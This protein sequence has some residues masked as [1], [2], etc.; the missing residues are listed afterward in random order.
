MDRSPSLERRRRSSRS[1]RCEVP[2]AAWALVRRGALRPLPRA[3]AVPD[4][5]D[6]LAARA[7]AARG[8]A[9]GTHATAAA[10]AAWS[11]AGGPP[12]ASPRESALQGW[13][14]DGPCWGRAVGP[15]YSLK[16][17][18]LKAATQ[19]RDPRHTLARTHA[20]SGVLAT[21]RRQT[22]RVQACRA[23]QLPASANNCH[24]CHPAASRCAPPP[25]SFPARYPSPHTRPPT[26]HHPL[27]RRTRAAS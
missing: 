21:A 10:R 7:R 19:S 15:S 24:R 14:R 13:L 3:P 18:R 2:A 9:R 25:P 4:R 12:A 22:R 26:A 1:S 11:P 23:A 16:K 8:R 20:Q 5:E 6:R 17:A 27:A